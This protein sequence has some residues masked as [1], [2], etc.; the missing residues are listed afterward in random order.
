MHIEKNLYLIRFNFHFDFGIHMSAC[1]ESFNLKR[2]TWKRRFCYEDRFRC[3]IHI[4][5]NS[6]PDTHTHT[7]IR[8]GWWACGQWTEDSFEKYKMP[9]VR[10]T[11]VKC[12]C[13]CFATIFL[14][15]NSSFL[16]LFVSTFVHLSSI[17]LI[18]FHTVWGH[19]VYGL[20]WDDMPNEP[21]KIYFFFFLVFLMWSKQILAFPMWTAFQLCT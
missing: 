12:Q 20:D 17:Q 2:I 3:V 15:K 14:N 19:H 4:Y 10:F 8:I 1:T 13:I 9:F 11:L 5:S 16:S 18:Q 21:H 7:Q 6:H